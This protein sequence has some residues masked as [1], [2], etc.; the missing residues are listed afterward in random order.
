MSE[1]QENHLMSDLSNPCKGGGQAKE[2]REV[3]SE[4]KYDFDIYF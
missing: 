3:K 2:P 1:T 4:V